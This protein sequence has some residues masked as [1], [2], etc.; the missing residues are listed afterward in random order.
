MVNITEVIYVGYELELLEAHIAEH[1]PYVN[2]IV[3]A[4]SAVTTTGHKKPMYVKDNWSRF[5]KYDVEHAEIPSDL[6]G[7]VTQ[8]SE[9]AGVLEDIIEWRFQGQ[10]KYK[11]EY[12]HP[13]VLKNADWI[14]HGD[15][16]EI[17]REDAWPIIK[18]DLGANMGWNHAS[19][20]L[21]NSIGYVNVSALKKTQPYRWCRAANGFSV[22]N[23]KFPIRQPRGIIGTGVVGWHFFS[24]YSRPEEFYWKMLNRPWTWG[25]YGDDI[26][27]LEEAVSKIR[28]ILDK[29]GEWYKLDVTD[30]LLKYITK[31]LV[32]DDPAFFANRVFEISKLPKC[33]QNNI[34]RFS[35]VEGNRGILS[36]YMV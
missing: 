11:K 27:T 22:A 32:I 21:Y 10:D 30:P 7:K 26:P 34:D 14:F 4:E 28:S 9:E 23:P 24:C 6:F 33:I 17:I 15:V 18:K 35:R 19:M 8:S 20:N 13:R 5:E 29:Q 36:R 31:E 16:D 25:T 3:V 2:R 1:R 12:M